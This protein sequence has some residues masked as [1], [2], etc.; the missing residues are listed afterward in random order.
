MKAKKVTSSVEIENLHSIFVKSPSVNK[1]LDES[2]KVL[3]RIKIPKRE[4][5]NN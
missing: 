4:V 2:S 1:L 5:K 3:N